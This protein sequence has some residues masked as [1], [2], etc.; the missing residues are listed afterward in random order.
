MYRLLNRDKIAIVACSNGLKSDKKR[1]MEKL[2]F[3]LSEMNLHPIFSHYLYLDE[4]GISYSGK[5]RAQE[6][7]EFYKDDSI[8]I[9]FD[10]SGGDIANE[11]LD[12]LNFD[13]IRKKL[14]YFCGYSDLTTILNAVYVKTGMPALLYQ[15][16]N[17]VY[18]EKQQKER[19]IQSFING[20]Y[21][22]F[23]FSFEF[24]RGSKLKG[25][26][27]GGNIRCFLKL[28]GTEYFPDF[29]GKILFLEAHSG[30]RPQMITYFSQLKQLHVFEQVEG[31]ILGTFSQLETS[32]LFK[33]E[34]LILDYIGPELPLV[35][36][37]EI[38]HGINSKAIFIGKEIT[39]IRK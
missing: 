6:L 37:E 19:F 5:K 15:I 8:K 22:L 38:G 17:L 10:V 28:A 9:I 12:E 4:E 30:L 39:L 33:V 18:D 29:K 11:I 35:K 14:K 3:V 20:N 21:D 36:T 16:S 26:V 34:E 32:S 31:I 13:L 27:V 24:I 25:I 7:M 2:N 1:I 23:R